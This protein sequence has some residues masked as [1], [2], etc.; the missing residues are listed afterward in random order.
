MTKNKM[1]LNRLSRRLKET[2]KEQSNHSAGNQTY[3]AK[4]GRPKHL[5][6]A[7]GPKSEEN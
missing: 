6:N 7:K 5:E 1:T 4:S 2:I 3:T